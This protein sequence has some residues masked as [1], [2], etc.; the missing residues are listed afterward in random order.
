MALRYAFRLTT[1]L[2]QADAF[3]VAADAFE[4]AGAPVAA[5]SVRSWADTCRRA[6]GKIWWKNPRA[7][8]IRNG[9]GLVHDEMASGV[10]HEMGPPGSDDI[11]D[12]EVTV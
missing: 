10:D 11:E 2:E 7:I 6:F 4:E 1:I 9:F 3:G 12:N 5:R 8:P